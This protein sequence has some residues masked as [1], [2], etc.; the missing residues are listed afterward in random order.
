MK[1]LVT[2]ANG[3][4]GKHL[5]RYLRGKGFEILGVDIV[6]GADIVG[7]VSDSD[8]VLRKLGSE[9]FDCIVHLAAIADIKKTV[10][11]PY[12]TYKV[13][14]YGTL[15]LLELGARKNL[16]RFLYASSA[17][18]YGVPI[19]RPAT[20]ATPF[21]PRLPYDYSKVIGEMLV[22][23]YGVHRRL[24]I[25]ITRSWLLFGEWEPKT[26]AV[27][28]FVKACLKGEKIPLFNGGQDV[29]DPT[30]AENYGR[31]AELVLTKEEA[32]GEAFNVGSGNAMSI[33]EMAER[34]KKLTNSTA[35]LEL[36]PPR[37]EFEKEPQIAY[38]SIE[39]L[40]RKLGYEPIVNFDEGIA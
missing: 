31:I 16:K 32:S 27:P 8:F 29:T 12:S 7:D 5:T 37:T 23:S 2:G 11:D 28:R 3:F 14:D 36:L 38:P 39:K 15:N 26:R 24:S 1:V 4:V 25:S 9:N 35:E 18:V 40:K 21:N 20:E 33:R 10:E 22:R 30:Y 13:N 17:N 19:D 34:I 6:S